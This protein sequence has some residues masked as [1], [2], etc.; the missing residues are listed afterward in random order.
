[1][2]RMRILGTVFSFLFSYTLA[3][4]FGAVFAYFFPESVNSIIVPTRTGVWLVGFPLVL[5]FIH[6]FTMMA[7][8]GNR[9]WPWILVP[10]VPA[11][12]FEILFG[13]AYIY[14][15]VIVGMIALIVGLLVNKL[16]TR[17]LP[18]FMARLW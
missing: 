7:L 9:K 12:G 6:I 3:P 13:I 5:F 17:S 4:H 15:P 14:I 11:I 10:L 1:M 16:F 18:A 2:A 8:G